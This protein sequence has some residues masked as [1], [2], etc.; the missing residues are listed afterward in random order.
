MSSGVVSQ[1]TRITASPALPRSAALSASST[2]FPQAAPGEALRPCAATSNS[3]SGSRRGWS[4]W[5]SSAGSIRATASSRSINPSAVMSTAHLIA[6]AAVRF[7]VRVC[8]R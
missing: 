8:R 5:S 1:R 4:S 7:A 3:A 6:A 2:I